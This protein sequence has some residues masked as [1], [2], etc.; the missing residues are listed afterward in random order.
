MHFGTLHI[1]HEAGLFNGEPKRRNEEER[2]HYS[3]V[4]YKNIHYQRG[5][6][7]DEQAHGPGWS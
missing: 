4:I 7:A 6:L 1:D 3:C 5:R 2:A